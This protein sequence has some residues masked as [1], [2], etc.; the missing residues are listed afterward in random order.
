M[1]NNDR[2]S[3]YCPNLNTPASKADAGH[4]NFAT[5]SSLTFID[6][7]KTIWGWEVEFEKDIYHGNQPPNS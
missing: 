3:S 5:F 7:K 4:P 6:S 2:S 1:A